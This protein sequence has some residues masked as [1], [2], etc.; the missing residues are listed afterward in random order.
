[1]PAG[2]AFPLTMGLISICRPRPDVFG[3]ELPVLLT[4]Y[5]ALSLLSL[6]FCSAAYCRLI[7]ALSRRVLP[8][9]FF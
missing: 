3:T 5:A 8:V 9:G 7:C 4:A 2:L 1:M 6:F